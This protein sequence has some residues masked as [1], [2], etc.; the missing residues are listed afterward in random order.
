VIGLFKESQFA[1]EETYL[2]K[3]DLLLA[4]TEGLLIR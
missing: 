4:Y 2:E 1:V 3:D